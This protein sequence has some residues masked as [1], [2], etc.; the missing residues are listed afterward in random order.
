M[1][2]LSY[3]LPENTFARGESMKLNPL[4]NNRKRGASILLLSFF[5]MIVLFTLASALFQIIPAEF[6]AASRA[7]V[8]VESHYVANSGIQHTLSWLEKKMEDFS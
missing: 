5:F 7:H 4:H 2:G 1:K 3:H 8:D 6:H